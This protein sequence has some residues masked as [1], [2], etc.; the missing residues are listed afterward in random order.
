MLVLN[1]AG[2]KAS[3]YRYLPGRHALAGIGGPDQLTVVV[4]GPLRPNTLAALRTCAAVI[5]PAGDPLAGPGGTATC[6]IGCSRPKRALSCTAPRWPP[7]RSAWPA[8]STPM[9]PTPPPT[10]PSAWQRHHG[11]RCSFLLL[12]T[13]RA[14][15]PA[16]IGP[17][18]TGRASI[19]PGQ[20]SIGQAERRAGRALDR[21]ASGRSIGPALDRPAS[22]GQRRAGQ[23]WTGQHWGG[24]RRGR[25]CREGRQPLR[26][27][28]RGPGLSKADEGGDARSSRLPPHVRKGINGVRPDDMFG[29][30]VAGLPAG[31]LDRLRC[32]RAWALASELTDL[33]AWL[34]AEGQALSDVLYE[35][36]GQNT[37]PELKPLLVGLRRA[38]H[39]CRRP[40]RTEHDVM[41]DLPADTAARIR[42]WLD[43]LERREELQRQLPEVLAAELA[44]TAAALGELAAD[45]RLRSGLAHLSRALSAELDKWIAEPDRRRDVRCS[46]GWPGTWPGRRQRPAHTPPSPSAALAAGSTA[47][48][49]C[50]PRPASAGTVSL[51]G[52]VG[53]P[54]RARRPRRAQRRTRT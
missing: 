30:R 54:R 27:R 53:C 8:A 19:G 23:H 52:T 36:I 43:R 4:G 44:G 32:A 46:R 47:A 29:V 31:G 16:R 9:A 33:S 18:S 1:V 39:G 3:V 2:I 45:P 25:S 26:R 5:I 10:P 41:D 21:P 11:G 37:R 15:G 42:T 50:R 48:P 22:G 7:P 35:L 34:A 24:P 13:P 51:T 14:S 12:G 38:V 20:A 49:P 17:T 40:D 28:R 6:G